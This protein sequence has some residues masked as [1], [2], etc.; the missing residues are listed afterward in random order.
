MRRVQTMESAVFD[1]LEAAAR[2]RQELKAELKRID[3][4]FSYAEWLV[5]ETGQDARS[6]PAR[7]KHREPSVVKRSEVSTIAAS[8]P[9]EQELPRSKAPPQMNGRPPLF[10]GAIASG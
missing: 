6:V 7:A 9:V 10:R 5:K 4:F 2:R 8:T 1:V 3:E